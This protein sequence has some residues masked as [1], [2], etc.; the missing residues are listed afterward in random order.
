MQNSRFPPPMY[1]FFICI[2]LFSCA[3]AQLYVNKVFTQQQPLPRDTSERKTVFLFGDDE[4]AAGGNHQLIMAKTDQ[5]VTST[6]S[7]VPY[8][9][10]KELPVDSRTTTNNGVRTKKTRE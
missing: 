1:L 7:T 9:S 4:D 6:P 3:P 10:K 2:L 5:P 8:E